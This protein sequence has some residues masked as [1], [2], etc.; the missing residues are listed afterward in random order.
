MQGE[1]LFEPGSS[2]W[3]DGSRWAVLGTNPAC[4]ELHMRPVE[5]VQGM[6]I[7]VSLSATRK[8]LMEDRIIRVSSRG[9]EVV[10]G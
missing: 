4:D 1:P 7:I 2:F 5:P 8:A 10:D 9:R 6:V 3:L